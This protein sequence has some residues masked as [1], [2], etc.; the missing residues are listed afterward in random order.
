MDLGP[1]FLEAAGVTVPDSMTARSLMPILESGQN[2]Q[3]EEDRTFVITGRERH[4]TDARHGNLP[5]PQRAIRRV[6]EILLIGGYN[7]EQEESHADRR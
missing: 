6:C 4:V 1:T 5:C 7:A 2:G 3:I